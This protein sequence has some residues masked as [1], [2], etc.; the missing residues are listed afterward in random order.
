MTTKSKQGNGT[1]AVPNPNH[2]RIGIHGRPRYDLLDD[3]YN[4]HEL[5]VFFRQ[6]P[7]EE[8]TAKVKQHLSD[9]HQIKNVEVKR[10][11]DGC[12]AAVQLWKANNIHT[13]VAGVP[14]SGGGSGGGGTVGEHYSLN[15][16]SKIPPQNTIDF[17]PNDPTE[18][19]PGKNV[20]TIA[21]LDTGVDTKF[22][23]PKY[24]ADNLE[25]T[26]DSPCFKDKKNGWNF[27]GNNDKTHDDNAP[28]HGTLVTQYI[29]NQFEN[30][31]KNGR[32][33][34][35]RIIPVKTHDENGKSDLFS[36]YCGIKYAIAK[37][38]DIINASWGFYYYDGANAGTVKLLNKLMKE[39]KK[40]GILFVTAAGNE[41]REEDQKA[42]A[43]YEAKNGAK[44]ANEILRDLDINPFYPACLSENNQNVIT[45]T[46][47]DGDNVASTENYSAL[48]VDL[49]VMGDDHGGEHS[50]FK[51]PF[52][53]N[54]GSQTF[55]G[56]SSFAAAIASGVIGAN[57][58]RKLYRKNVDRASFISGLQ[59]KHLLKINGN[60]SK[61]IMNG[62]YVES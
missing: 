42:K 33:N 21:V 15:F 44:P 49:G 25:N 54:D 37:G 59:A 57:S 14:V 6:P 32:G 19:V 3:T 11:A 9:H 39:L 4:P 16:L 28:K 23:N 18:I 58:K 34:S 35:P 38:A 24:I 41:T 36:I 7:T 30:A 22:V 31:L 8:D 2:N 51:I 60:L 55:I 50:K 12:G 47:A 13:V 20:V 56:G 27:V 5:I 40:K 53:T 1:E 52:R 17:K 62:A 10:C 61:K 48:F 46:T 29:I 45:I 43:I 26:D